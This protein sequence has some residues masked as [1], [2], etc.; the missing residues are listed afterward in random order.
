MTIT[1][2]TKGKTV[3]HKKCALAKNPEPVICPHNLKPLSDLTNDTSQIKTITTKTEG[4][5]VDHKKC[6]LAK[7]PEPEICLQNLK[8]LNDLI[9]DTSQKR[10]ITTK[11]KGKRVDHRTCALAKTQSRGLSAEAGSVHRWFLQSWRSEG[12]LAGVEWSCWCEASLCPR[13]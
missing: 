8:A 6:A 11:I 1:T 12:L 10:T 3:D 5:R 7:N 9:N 2:K 4:K 13:W